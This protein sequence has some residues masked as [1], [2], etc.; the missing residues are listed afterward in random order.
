MAA[1][2]FLV[3]IGL[4]CYASAENV[5]TPLLLPNGL[6]NGFNGFLF[7]DLTIQTFIGQMAVTDS[8]TYYTL[9]CGSTAIS[10]WPGPDGC[11]NSN[12]Y[13]FSASSA[14]TRFLMPNV[15]IN[16]GPTNTASTAHCVYTTLYNS[17]SKGDIS[18]TSPTIVTQHST[19]TDS[20]LYPVFFPTTAAAAATTS[21]ISEA[22]SI[23]TTNLGPT[24]TPPPT[25]SSSPPTSTPTTAPTTHSTLSTGSKAG[26]GI[27][28]PIGVF[29]LA[30]IALLLYRHNKNEQRWRLGQMNN[31]VPLENVAGEFE[32]GKH[33]PVPDN[34]GVYE[35][36]GRQSP[37]QCPELEG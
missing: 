36:D 5:S 20:T 21:L 11:I 14:N 24:I 12:S 8:T 7:S 1:I 25:V 28:V 16:C 2:A 30:G 32:E 22:S 10:F 33:V 27:G 34:S 23:S 35:M 6:F 17:E 15:T 37:T 9:D 13:T 26:I 18:I 19:E 31:L 4:L 3:A 29:A